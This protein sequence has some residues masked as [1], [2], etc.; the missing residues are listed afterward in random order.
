MEAPKQNNPDRFKINDIYETEK[1]V[2][3]GSTGVVYKG[4]NINTQEPVAVKILNHELS[5]HDKFVNQL[6][7]EI[8]KIV[9]LSHPNIVSVKE[10]GKDEEKCYIIL[11]YLECESLAE[12][13]KRNKIPQI[14][15]SINIMKQLALALK[16]T[17]ENNLVHK[18][19]TPSNIL[20]SSNKQV[21]LTGFGI[22]SALST[23]WLTMTGT[24]NSH[25]EYMSPEQA[26]GEDAD[27]RSDIYSFG[28][29]V[30]QL[31]TGDVPFKRDATSKSIL[32]V[33]MKHINSPPT[34]PSDKN[35]NIPSWL[36]DVV[37]KCLEKKA[38]DRFQ[39]GQE[40]YDHLTNQTSPYQNSSKV[41]EN[42]N[43]SALLSPKE[44]DPSDL[45]VPPDIKQVTIAPDEIKDRK[46]FDKLNSASNR[47]TYQQKVVGSLQKGATGPIAVSNESEIIKVDEV[48]NN[49]FTAQ[50]KL[51][52]F[53]IV[54]LLVI[55]I[56]KK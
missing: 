30:Y 21:K 41:S 50:V 38:V 15:D 49:I 42:K 22:N 20:L 17:G 27:Y 54:V 53:L 45:F 14:T 9:H 32:A 19:V 43:E 36:E 3:N 48:K 52:L 28:I 8:N 24:S 11:E 13:I 16:Y 39:S 12:Y 2:G 7:I 51:L 25:V 55:L 23:A 46:A 4:R 18:S 29:V 47:Q 26:E 44:I 6:K 1:V 40:I 10:A 5:K 34:P 56:F 33:A 31:L 37:L 35:G